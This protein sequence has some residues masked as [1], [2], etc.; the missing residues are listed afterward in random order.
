MVVVVVEE[1]QEE[2]E[3]QEQEQEE[4]EVVE[5][6]KKKMEQHMLEDFAAEVQHYYI[7]K[8]YNKS[9]SIGIFSPRGFDELGMTMGTQYL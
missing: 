3:E 5:G 2:E 7:E 1:E 6:L 9:R 4:E 8:I